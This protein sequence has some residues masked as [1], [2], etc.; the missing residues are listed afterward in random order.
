ME[1]GEEREESQ[2]G[3]GP[4]GGENRRKTDL[5]GGGGRRA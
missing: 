2:E 5:V 4:R 1:G 3:D